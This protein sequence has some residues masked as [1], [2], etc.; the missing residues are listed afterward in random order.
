[1]TWMEC[2]V[3]V[4]VSRGTVPILFSAPFT[5]CLVIRGGSRTLVVCVPWSLRGQ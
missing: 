2:F 3:L 4:R 1:M 5:W